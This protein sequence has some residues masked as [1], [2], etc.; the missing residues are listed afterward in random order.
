MCVRGE[1]DDGDWGHDADDGDGGECR[2]RG[3]E[4]RVRK[5]RFLHGVFRENKNPA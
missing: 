5:R 3:E 2:R 1:S 4:R